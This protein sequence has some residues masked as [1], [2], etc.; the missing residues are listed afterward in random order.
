MFCY[1]AWQNKLFSKMEKEL[2]VGFVEG[3]PSEDSIQSFIH[4]LIVLDDVMNLIINSKHIESLFTRGSHYNNL[5]V[6]YINQK[7]VLSGK[8]GEVY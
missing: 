7:Q 3:L 8:I 2:W 1:G 4:N 5:I 6:I